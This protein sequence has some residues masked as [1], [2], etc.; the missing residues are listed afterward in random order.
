MRVK[1]EELGWKPC[2]NDF[3]AISTSIRDAKGIEESWKNALNKR[4]SPFIVPGKPFVTL[5]Q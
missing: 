1:R 5:E 2:L 4:M 3:K